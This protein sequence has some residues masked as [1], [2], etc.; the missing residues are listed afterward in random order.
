MKLAY[1]SSA[2]ARAIDRGDCTQIEFVELCAREIACDGVVLDVAQFPRLDEDYLAQMRKMATDLGLDI[3]AVA[4]ASFFSAD[5][6]TMQRS[7]A[8][9]RTL[10][11]PLLAAPLATETSLPWSEQRDRLASATSL[12]KAA[13]VTLALRDMPGTFAA[14]AHELKRVSKEADSAWLRFALTLERFAAD[15]VAALASNTVLL[16]CRACAPAHVDRA[17]GAFRGYL[18]LD[19]TTG[20]ADAANAKA[21]TTKWRA[22]L[23]ASNRA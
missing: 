9:A 2:F 11:A 16:W 14:G 8:L 3:A 1:A 6:A 21:Q 7:L 12:A 18:V 17:F 4:D 20:S 22:P 13:N 19:N 10:G 15:D 5:D 23:E